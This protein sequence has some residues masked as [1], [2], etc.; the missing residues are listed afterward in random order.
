MSNLGAW[1]QRVMSTV[2]STMTL[3]YLLQLGSMR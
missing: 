2:V 3:W 1:V